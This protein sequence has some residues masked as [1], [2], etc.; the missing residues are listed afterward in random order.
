MEKKKYFFQFRRVLLTA[1]KTSIFQI[2]FF[3][4]FFTS[5]I[6]KRVDNN[7]E[8]QVQY[9][10]NNNEE[11]QK[12]INNSGGKHVFLQRKINQFWIE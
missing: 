5:Q 3:L 2:C 4:L 12:I 7:T 8:N 6:S 11:E 1:N 10:N 9:D